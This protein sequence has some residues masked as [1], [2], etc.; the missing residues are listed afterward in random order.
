MIL[1]PDPL[2]PI[3]IQIAQWLEDEILSGV[4]PP[5]ERIYSQYQL[6]ELFNINPATAAKGLNLLADD[7]LLYKRRGLGMFVAADARERIQEKRRT[8]TVHKLIEQL[9]EEAKRLDMSEDDLI[10]LLH[11]A[12][13]KEVPSP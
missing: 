2:T 9:A 5:N 11:Q 6:A 4:L 10:H 7:D 12:L 3:Y 1:K 13:Q 8:V